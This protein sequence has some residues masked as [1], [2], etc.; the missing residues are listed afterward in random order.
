MH[1]VKKHLGDSNIEVLKDAIDEIL[2]VLKDD[3]L[4]DN[5]RKNEIDGLLGIEALS[6]DEFNTIQV[7]AQCLSDYDQSKQEA[8][9][10]VNKIDNRKEQD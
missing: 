6:D 5:Q 3:T 8:L 1:L 10:S 9:N 7:L 2:A 4:N